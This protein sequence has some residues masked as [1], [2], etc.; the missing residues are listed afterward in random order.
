MSSEL[1][2]YLELATCECCGKEKRDDHVA[3]MMPQIVCICEDCLRDNIWKLRDARR[4]K[5]YIC[6]KC[7]VPM[8]LKVEIK[9]SA[10]TTFTF[11]PT[12]GG[13]E[14]EERENPSDCDTEIEESEAYFMCDNDDCEQCG[15]EVNRGNINDNLATEDC[16]WVDHDVLEPFMLEFD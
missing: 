10:P 7:G 9:A 13:W 11:T 16:A 3:R 6:Q 8:Q 15:I 1:K 5:E 4:M 14:E 12:G 2:E